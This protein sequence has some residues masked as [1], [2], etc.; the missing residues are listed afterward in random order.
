ML[1]AAGYEMRLAGSSVSRVRELRYFRMTATA[2]E[3]AAAAVGRAART[4]NVFTEK[5][6]GRGGGESIE[7]TVACR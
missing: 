3:I 7:F 4:V 5:A 1:I 2:I 6:S